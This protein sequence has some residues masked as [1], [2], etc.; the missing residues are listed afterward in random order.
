MFKVVLTNCEAWV[1][2]KQ[3]LVFQFLI[4]YKSMIEMSKK[5]YFVTSMLACSRRSDSR[6]REKKFTK[7]KKQGVQF[8]SL[9]YSLNALNRLLLCLYEVNRNQSAARTILFEPFEKT[10]GRF[11]RC[12]H[13][14]K[15]E[16]IERLVVRQCILHR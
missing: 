6:A 11:E 8:D 7:K 12:F 14:F 16:L 9:P 15:S 13:S 2:R 10:F 3:C 1:Q 5:M 4:S